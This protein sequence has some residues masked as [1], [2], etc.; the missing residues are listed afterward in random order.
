M[1]SRGASYKASAADPQ[2]RLASSKPLL[3]IRLRSLILT[4]PC[5]SS[6]HGISAGLVLSYHRGRHHP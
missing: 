2:H 1:L 6:T 5:G 4:D 3:G